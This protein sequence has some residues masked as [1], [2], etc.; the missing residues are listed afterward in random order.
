MKVLVSSN[1]DRI[2]GFTMLGSEAGEVMGVVQ[3]AMLSRLP[4]QELR[5]A[6]LAHLTFA[7]AL[8]PL[9]SS[10]PQRGAH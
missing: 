3:T 1:D 4:Y 10:V 7:E 2:L 9:L 5:D 6:V 8:G